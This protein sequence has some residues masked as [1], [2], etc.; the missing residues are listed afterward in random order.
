MSSWEQAQQ[1]WKAGEKRLTA[2]A[3]DQAVAMY[4]VTEVESEVGRKQF[5]AVAKASAGSLAEDIASTASQIF[6]QSFKGKA[7]V[8]QRAVNT[9]RDLITK[10]RGFSMF[11]PRID[12]TADALDMV[13][14]DIPRTGPL[15]VSQTLVLGVMLQ[16]MTD[17]PSDSI[18]RTLKEA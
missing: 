8:T 14:K 11:D 15:D 9:V 3:P 13:L 17:S 5:E 7:T 12:R 4:R 2:A 1:Q 10:L 16:S 18:L 6:T